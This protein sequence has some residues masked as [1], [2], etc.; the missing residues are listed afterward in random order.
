MSR[1][2]NVIIRASAGTGKTFQLSN[3]FLSLL[4]AG[5]PVDEI[6]ATT[7]TRKAA[8]EILDRVFV[9]LAEAALDQ[10]RC[11]ELA[12]HLGGQN[13]LTRE[14]AHRLLVEL[15]RKLHRLRVC[16]LDSFFAQLAGSFSFEI[17]L[18]PAW[19]IVEDADEGR[20]RNEAIGVT[21]R[22]NRDVVR[23]I[24]LMNKG[25]AARNVSDT[26][27]EAVNQLYDVYLVT[28]E[29]A[30][31]TIHPPSGL[32][33]DEL[34]ETLEA[35][36][37]VD[38][39]GDG[40]FEQ[41]RDKDVSSALLGDWDEFLSG[42]LSKKVREGD[43]TY[44]KK[45]I[46]S[47]A[48]ELYK[49]LLRHARSALMKE[50][51]AQT[52]ATYEL[53][54][55]F[56]SAYRRLQEDA[57]IMR[58]SDVTRILAQAQALT[59]QTDTEQLGFR[60]DGQIR[61]LLLDEFQD[62]SLEQWQVLRPFAGR[63]A[64][65]SRGQQSFVWSDQTSLFCVGDVKQAIYGWRGGIAQ[66]FDA[67]EDE[68]SGLR[69]TQLNKSHRSAQP[70]IDTVNQVFQNL[71][72]HKKLD[73]ASPALSQWQDHFEPHTTSKSDLPGFVEL[74]V[75]PEEEN[76]DV[77]QSVL[78]AAADRVA[79][80][81][82]RS[83]G[84]TVGVLCRRND[85]VGRMIFELRAREIAASEEGGNPLTDSAAVQ[86]VLS[87]LWLADHPGDSIAAAHVACS[88]L[89]G[90]V[91]FQRFDDRGAAVAVARRVRRS[92]QSAGLAL[93]ISSW[94]RGLE[95]FCN[96]RD[97]SRLLQLVEL[98]Y[99]FPLEETLRTSRFVEFVRQRRVL[100]PTSAPV[101]VMTI[102]QAKGLQFD[103][104]VL[105]DLDITLIGQRDSHVVGRPAPTAA[106]DR[107][108]VYRNTA[109]QSIL[110]A[111]LQDVF[112]KATDQTL[113]EA[114]CVLYV[115]MTRAVHAMH[116]FVSHKGRSTHQTSAG[117]LRTTLHDSRASERDG[118]GG[119]KLL[120]AHGD[121][122]WYLKSNAPQP[123]P[124]ADEP[125]SA[126]TGEIR[127]ANMPERRVGL[128]RT[129]ASRRAGGTKRRVGELFATEAG[130]ARTR[131]TL[132]HAWFQLVEWLDDGP[133]NEKQLVEAARQIRI[134][135][136]EVAR[137]KADFFEILE[138]PAICDLLH[139][140]F[141]EVPCDEVIQSVLPNEFHDSTLRAE[142]FTERPFA[143]RDKAQIV[144]GSIDRL[145]LLYRGDQIIAADVIDYKS[146]AVD[147]ADTA[148]IA[149]TCERYRPQ[150]ETY[151]KAV[152]ET[153]RIDRLR[154]ATRLVFVAGGVVRSL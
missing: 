40:R 10:T 69:R 152:A 58:F 66:I 68:V 1:F 51:A 18:P 28:T 143:F 146:D 39:K 122:Q 71:T 31:L 115:S 96:A 128:E 54:D 109:I 23:L 19:R 131:G 26:I 16:T 154:I 113:T 97:Y 110:P 93:T 29:Q 108:C 47:A 48:I 24:H 33:D 102:H 91:E 81:V 144:I 137:R 78:T 6:L 80:I 134:G 34:R 7:F 124:P 125:F 151:R 140:K 101:R 42:G 62:T 38:F 103:A 100:D 98:G 82:A 12:E 142:V 83:P 30:W 36:S 9:R 99:A 53:L 72:R 120:Y 90:L 77:D 63:V 70:V 123:T 86:A 76:G 75:A 141:Y 88:P 27:R 139:R 95:P 20:L 17:G 74:C 57:R 138:K 85:F 49:K 145:V 59:A 73:E 45:Q 14:E 135:E 41:A 13:L 35:L 3:R 153:F 5:A 107:V 92:L 15:T 50:L 119:E 114:L 56:A 79:E 104:V 2:D 132:L 67:L 118:K 44:Y 94:V 22:E 46:P 106:I 130:A 121:P 149:A 4:H 133:P 60:M 25:E 61:H 117:L 147:G 129:S 126:A 21:L 89:A 111:D 11:D 127:L 52:K 116:M 112:Q 136:A 65:S 64:G 8:A 84:S 105:I 55:R 150:L 32:S 37:V 87:L 43:S 148:A